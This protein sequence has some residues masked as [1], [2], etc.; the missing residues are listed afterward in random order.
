MDSYLK[1]WT[2]ACTLAIAWTSLG[3][4][5]AQVPATPPVGPP[6][7]PPP[8]P[9]PPVAS[10]GE[11]DPEEEVLTVRALKQD[12][13]IQEV[14]GAVSALGPRQLTL[15]QASGDDVRLL[16]SRTPSLLVESSFGR[17]FPRF[18][19]RGLGNTDFDLNASQPVSLVLDEVVLENPVVKSYPLFDLERIEVLRGPQGTLFG[20]NTPAGVI[21]FD[22]RP[23][24]QDH[25][26]YGRLNAGRFGF[27][28]FE[29]AT[30]GSLIDGLSAARFSTLYQRR[31]HWIDNRRTPQAHDLGG[32]DQVA[33]RFQLL[34]T[35]TERLSA[36]FKV[37]A[38]AQ[39]ASSRVFYA[40]VI[41]P[42]TDALVPDFDPARV[43]HDGQNTQRLRQ[44]GGAARLRY[45]FG[46]LSLTSVTGVELAHLYARGDIDGGFGATFAPPSGP[47]PIPFPSETADGVPHLR[48]WSEELRLQTTA[49]EAFDLLLGLYY[50][51]EELEVSSFSYDSLALGVQNGYADQHQTTVDYAVFGAGSFK[52]TPALTLR[53]GLRFTHDEKHMRAERRAGGSPI[54]APGTG[55]LR[56]D[57]SANFV[58]GDLSAV[59]R[60]SPDLN[61]YGKVAR[62]FRA[63]SIQGRIL[64]GD[65]LSVA[66]TESVVSLEAGSKALWLDRRLRV[67]LAAFLY[68]VENQQLTAVGGTSNLNALLNADQTLGYG[69][70]LDADLHPTSGLRIAF[71]ASYNHTEIMDDGLSVAPCGG[72]CTV[73]DPPGAVPQTVLIDG[74]SL[75]HAPRVIANVLARYGA[76]IAEGAELFVST[77]WAYRSRVHFFLYEAAEFESPGLL[78]GGLRAGYTTLDQR[79]ELA[80]YVRNLLDA[81]V[82]T[83]GIDFN[84][85]TGFFVDP[86]TFGVEAIGRFF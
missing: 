28:A 4:A 77:D 50:F 3:P 48:Q 35:P 16:S 18:Y 76:P 49:F 42:G 13:D 52:P 36:L 29:G 31:S 57:P 62:G 51:R 59:L 37:H 70:E 9:R 24:T 73:L 2:G 33:A 86:R 72:G 68:R 7:S 66:D 14:P 74:N 55:P 84:N 22:T 11:E 17:T 34:L 12:T 6:A 20:R 43:W 80:A 38:H 81:Q 54:G 41:E 46:P 19:I 44:M 85:L 27:L 26:S 71:S 45:D 78:L 69:L 60:L 61:V 21:R 23:P 53:A 32:F 40:N 5:A 67:N 10:A 56:E 63:P 15:W 1:R 8:G 30:G 58:S 25:D 75:P 47:G 82:R 65:A 83:G 64:F 39:Q 79:L